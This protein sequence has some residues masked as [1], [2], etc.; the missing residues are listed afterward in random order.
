MVAKMVAA[1]T[2]PTIDQ[3]F[4]FLFSLGGRVEITPCL[5]ELTTAGAIYQLKSAKVP[6]TEKTLIDQLGLDYLH[7]IRSRHGG[8]DG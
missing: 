2:K 7:A 4:M 5:H 8:A 1:N 6:V 3:A